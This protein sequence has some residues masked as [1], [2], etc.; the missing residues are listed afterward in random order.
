MIERFFKE[1][2]IGKKHI[3][4]ALG[5]IVI[6]AGLILITGITA[7]VDKGTYQ[8]RQWPITGTIDVKMTP[9][10][11]W[12]CFSDI[13]TWNK[14]ETLYFTSDSEGGK[15]DM[16]MEVRF[17]DGSIA[18]ISGTCRV[19]MPTSP[20]QAIALVTEHGF[21]S[22]EDL[23]AKLIR[24][25]VRN[26]LRL[27]ANLMSARESYSEQR[28]DYTFWA[29]DQIQNGLYKTKEEE[30]TITDLVTGEEIQKKFKVILINKE[31][32][33]IYQQNP[34]QDTGITLAN[35]EIK[36]FNYS[37]KVKQQIARQQDALMAV[38]TAKA[39]AAK[40]E[41]L[42]I[43]KEAE[44]KAN[45][46]QAKYEEEQAKI[47]AVVQA[48]RDKE[49]AILQAEKTK[50][51]NELMRDA[52]R[53]KKEEEILLGQGEAE[54]K[55]LVMSADGALKQKLETYE[56]VMEKFASAYAQRSVPSAVFVGGGG[57]GSNAADQDSMALMWQNALGVMMMKQ[58]GL[59][60]SIRSN[61]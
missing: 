45:V 10:M 23:E 55:R 35:F 30:R 47:K 22:Y 12:K 60:L 46:I 38:E 61:N 59:D 51:S 58:L 56:R 20:Q 18:L 33:P 8:I 13:K 41:Q 53:F 2:G 9:G 1:M 57:D 34:L 21:K 11:W 49:V 28:T 6:I 29:W 40:A 3:S 25:V 39:E 50:R 27:T 19:M 52:A 17:N 48:E 24:P 44:G 15:Q 7:T 37:D 26:S 31:G 54:R 14:A 36:V 32:Q 42:K 16:S 5:V 43:Q 4:I